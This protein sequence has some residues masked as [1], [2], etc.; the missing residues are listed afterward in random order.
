MITDFED[1]SLSRVPRNQLV[2]RSHLAEACRAREVPRSPQRNQAVTSLQGA[3]RLVDTFIKIS[4]NHTINITITIIIIVV[5]VVIDIDIN[6]KTIA[7]R[8]ICFT[9]TES[10]RPC[11]N[12]PRPEFGNQGSPQEGAPYPYDNA[13]R[14]FYHEDPAY[15]GHLREKHKDKWNGIEM[16]AEFYRD[17]YLERYH[18][19][20]GPPPSYQRRGSL[21]L[22]Q[23]LVALLD[24]P[25][26]ATFITWT[27][28]GLEFKLIEPEEVARRWGIQKN[29]PAMN[30]D[31]LSRSLRYYYEKGIMQK[32]AGERYVY[33]FVCD[34]EALFSMAFPDNHRPILKSDSHKEDFY[35]PPTSQ[36]AESQS[37]PLGAASAHS[38]PPIPTSMRAAFGMA[39]QHGNM[40]MMSEQHRLHYMQEMHRM[41][42]PNPYIEGCV[43]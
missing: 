9:V 40:S 10:V 23:F 41:Y 42:G 33:K 16:K 27:G 35:K 21:Q 4:K 11:A 15:F 43:Y 39:P 22:W 28:R 34:P 12:Y 13:M 25:S 24:D 18:H 32:V 3:I 31:K 6:I 19:R 5:V 7:Q 2:N 29:R 38:S 8:P 26:N 14:F 30:Y 37:L 36:P 17:F 1:P 20:D